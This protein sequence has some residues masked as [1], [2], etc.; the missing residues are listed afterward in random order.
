MVNAAL[1]ELEFVAEHG[2]KEWS[3]SKQERR[4]DRY[5]ILTYRK[6]F[7]CSTI[8]PFLRVSLFEVVKH[9]TENQPMKF[10]GIR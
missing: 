6:K 4:L 7:V 10:Y 1:Q 9:I 5:H 3:K 8:W 2:G